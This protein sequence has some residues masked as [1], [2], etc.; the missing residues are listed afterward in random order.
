MIK[1]KED[2]NSKCFICGADL[3]RS[4]ISSGIPYC[5]NCKD[6]EMEKTRKALEEIDFDAC[7]DIAYA[8]FERAKFD[9]V[10][11][12]KDMLSSGSKRSEP[13]L[14]EVEEFLYSE[15]AKTLA[16]N[17]VLEPRELIRNM[18]LEVKAWAKVND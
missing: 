4:R 7:Y 13:T 1:N 2:F 11:A 15:W 10:N 6:A 18:I 12:L 3:T 17:E 8:I 14:K 9:Y 5:D 16:C